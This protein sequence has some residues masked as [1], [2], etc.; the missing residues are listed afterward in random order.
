MQKKGSE[1]ETAVSHSDSL[2][3]VPV[4]TAHFRMK[5][6]GTGGERQEGNWLCA[7]YPGARRGGLLVGLVRL[8]WV[9]IGTPNFWGERTG[10][11]SGVWGMV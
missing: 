9:C 7:W 1:V 3:P 10:A 6:K 11:W 8:F 5:W 2:N 4:E